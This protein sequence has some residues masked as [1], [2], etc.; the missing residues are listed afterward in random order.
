MS[1]WKQKYAS[2]LVSPEEA[3]RQVKNGDRI[4]LG[5]MCSEPKTVIRAIEASYVEDVEMVQF[6]RGSTASR[7]AAK[8]SGRFKIKTF[9]VGAGGRDSEG[10][11]SEYDYIPLFH[12]QVPNF[13]RNRRIPIDVA[14]VQVSEP[15][16][17]GRFS[18]GISVDTASAA[19]E[20]ARI[21]I[22]QVNPEMPRTHGDTFL[23]FE[24]IHYLVDGPEPL[25][26]LPEETLGPREKAISGYVSE[27]IEDGSIL[28]F[29]FAGI[30][31]GLMDFLKDHRHLGVH[32]EIVTDPLIDLIEC[33]IVDNSTKKMYRGKSLA[34]CC[35]GTR[36]LYDYVNDNPLVEFYP[37]DAILSPS[38]IASHD[39]M[40]AVNLAIQVDLRGQIRQGSPT[41]TAFEGSGGDHD[42]M[43]GASLSKW[44]RSII[45]LRS[46]SLR[47]G[48]STIVPSFG[49][50][51]AVI[52]NRGDVNYIV[53]EYGIAYLGGK[54]IRDRAMA[55]IEIAHPDHRENLMKEA[56]EMGYVYQDQFY[57][58]VCSP[59]FRRRM[60]TDRVF[61]GGIKAHIRIIKP[62]D[63]SMMRDL[64]YNLSEES[65]YFRYF[66]PRRSMP[67][68]N[69]QQY[70]NLKEEDGISLVVTVGPR[71]NRKIIAEARFMV[72]PG[73]S[74]PDVAFMVD[75]NY[76]RR[77]IASALLHYLIEIAKERGFPGL[78]ADVLF[79]NHPMTAVFDKLPFVLHKTIADGVISLT[80][81]FDEYKTGQEEQAS[82]RA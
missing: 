53:T 75:E 72:E 49:P 81:N 79:S 23:S 22:A 26:E 51:A 65:V 12:S 40:I 18:L 30:S 34:T 45:C 74:Y 20:S 76:Q 2:K 13:F 1:L 61:K 17:F 69:L 54:S 57:Y 25:H 68:K 52:M 31:R 71:E 27:L 3:A 4:Y 73:N 32:T 10:E 63:E 38:F 9:F 16:R 29:G 70:V 24:Q 11:P 62:T 67:H 42:F 46:T 37:S 5:S 33:G 58:R 48:K 50:K 7:L 8:E 55:L 78:K 47:T 60:R 39:R 77:G 44:G 43:R 80:F 59:E 82:A 56:R 66:S 6:L 15:D 14:V 28:H 21:V 36:R 35:M 19:T 64:F 41:W